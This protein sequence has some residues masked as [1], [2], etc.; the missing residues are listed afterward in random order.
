MDV[1][2]RERENDFVNLKKSNGDR[3]RFFNPF[4]PVLQPKKILKTI[5][6]VLG[7]VSSRV[8]KSLGHVF[9]FTDSPQ[10]RQK[11][12]EQVSTI[13]LSVKFEPVNPENKKI[14]LRIHDMKLHSTYIRIKEA[15]FLLAPYWTLPAFWWKTVISA[16]DWIHLTWHAVGSFRCFLELQ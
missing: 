2:E 5:N 7:L 9:S 15:H 11:T 4:L 13:Y 3:S 12:N 10:V 14:G 8:W 1:F 16:D 6:F